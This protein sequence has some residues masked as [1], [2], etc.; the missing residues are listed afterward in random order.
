VSFDGM[1]QAAR[2][3]RRRDEVKPSARGQMPVADETRQ[4]LRD[5]I[6]AL[7]VIPEPPIQPLRS[8][9]LLDGAHVYGHR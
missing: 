3:S 5:G 8:K 7:K 2:F 6:S 9:R 4:P 1:D